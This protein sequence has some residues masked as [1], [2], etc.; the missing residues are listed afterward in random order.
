MRLPTLAVSPIACFC[1]WCIGFAAHADAWTASTYDGCRARLEGQLLDS[2]TLTA[3]IAAISQAANQGYG[4][5]SVNRPYRKD[6]VNLLIP[7]G[8]AS[9]PRECG[10]SGGNQPLCWSYPA[11]KQ[12][13]CNPSMGRYVEQ[14]QLGAPFNQAYTES[15]KFFLFFVLGH[16][17]GHLGFERSAGPSHLVPERRG[18]QLL[19]HPLLQAREDA[20]SQCDR[21]GVE[22]ACAVLKSDRASLG[23]K[24]SQPHDVS[25]LFQ[26]QHRLG[27]YEPDDDL[28]L[29]DS[30]YES[31]SLRIQAVSEAL[32]SCSNDDQETAGIAA[33]FFGAALKGAEDILRARQRSGWA[34][35]PSYGNRAPSHFRVVSGEAKDHY[36][37]LEDFD[38]QQ[39]TTLT[40]AKAGQDPEY[41]DL[42]LENRRGLR[43]ISSRSKKY[44]WDLLIE[45][46]TPSVGRRLEHV[47][48]A[49]SEPASG[50]AC[51]SR[52]LS[53]RRL[54]SKETVAVA[55]NA[56]VVR[57]ANA[58]V[59]Y[60]PIDSAWDKRGVST[61]RRYHGTAQS[62]WSS[63]EDRM[64]VSV[65]PAPS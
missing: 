50:P 62:I 30:S 14:M 12:I 16:E 51:V 7:R 21:H 19:C 41:T 32:S 43:L 59:V 63:D 22:A 9:W 11:L 57:R 25:L 26:V 23:L 38:G 5:W 64:I 20:E 65:V 45:S 40:I 15:Q 17:L 55:G 56:L 42:T 48:V 46:R 47:E 36:L 10:E 2:S 18:R 49:C 28:C 33:R 24:G 44:G 39:S 27:E 3:G 58:V 31:F 4:A 34:V 52:V 60:Q 6:R 29:G 1:G 35:S 53:S 54:L 8:G 13:I 37:V 61:A